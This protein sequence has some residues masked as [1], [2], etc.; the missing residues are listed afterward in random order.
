M[1]QMNGD[2]P[3]KCPIWATLPPCR[4]RVGQPP[5]GIGADLKGSLEFLPILPFM[6]HH[7]EECVVHYPRQLAVDNADRLVWWVQ[8]DRCSCFWDPGLCGLES[9]P[10]ELLLNPRPFLPVDVGRLIDREM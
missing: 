9:G 4:G 10:A 7:Q 1:Q 3:I 2:D 6:G 5:T 8:W